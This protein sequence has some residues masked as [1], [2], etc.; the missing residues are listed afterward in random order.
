MTRVIVDYGDVTLELTLAERTDAEERKLAYQ[1]AAEFKAK[2][3]CQSCG[4]PHV[5]PCNVI[6]QKWSG[7]WRDAKCPCARELRKRPGPS[8]KKALPAPPPA[9]WEVDDVDDDVG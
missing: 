2:H 6:V 4:H 3:G 9:L 7:G 8:E 1:R 5:G